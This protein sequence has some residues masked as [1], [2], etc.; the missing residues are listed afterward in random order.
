MASSS[1]A[2]VRKWVDI[3]QHGSFPEDTRQFNDLIICTGALQESFMDLKKQGRV[4][5]LDGTDEELYFCG[6]WEKMSHFDYPGDIDAACGRVNV[7]VKTSELT[8]TERE[9]LSDTVVGVLPPGAN[10]MNISPAWDALTHVDIPFRTGEGSDDELNVLE[11]PMQSHVLALINPSDGSRIDTEASFSMTF[12]VPLR[13]A[14]GQHLYNLDRGLD[15]GDQ[16]DDDDDDDLDN[17]SQTTS[18]SSQVSRVTSIDVEF[19]K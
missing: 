13:E 10:F 19:L 5:I 15:H 12:M 1:P 14:L 3:N 9:H 6:E 8:E 17:A 7:S 4:M 18:Q 11:T 16:D 2:S